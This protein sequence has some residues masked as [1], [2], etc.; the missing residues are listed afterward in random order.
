MGMFDTLYYSKKMPDGH[1]TSDGYQTKALRKRMDWYDLDDGTLL[2]KKIIPMGEWPEEGWDYED[3]NRIIPITSH[4]L[5]CGTVMHKG[6]QET[7]DYRL[8][9]KEGVLTQIDPLG[10]NPERNPDDWVRLDCEDYWNFLRE[11]KK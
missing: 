1:Q 8:H 3:V 11:D 6:R 10:L 4:I 2:L 9:F 7:F 5:C